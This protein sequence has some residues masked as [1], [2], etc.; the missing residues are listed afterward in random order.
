MVSVDYQLAA[1]RRIMAMG[2]ESPRARSIIN[3]SRPVYLL[4]PPGAMTVPAPP[5][6]VGNITPA[7]LQALADGQAPHVALL[8]VEVAGRFE[9]VAT[10]WPVLPAEMDD[11]EAVTRRFLTAGHV[12]EMV[13]SEPDI[14]D[15]AGAVQDRQVRPARVVFPD[16]GTRVVDRWICASALD[17]AVFD[18]AG[19]PCPALRL[20]KPQ[21]LPPAVA[22]IGYPLV[23]G[24]AVFR[25]KADPYLR[26][27]FMAIGKPAE[28]LGT[29]ARKSTEFLHDATTLPGFSGAPVFDPATGHVVGMHVRGSR[30]RLEHLPAGMAPRVIDRDRND[31][32]LA[33]GM[34]KTGWLSQILAGQSDRPPDDAPAR[35]WTGGAVPVP[36]EAEALRPATILAGAIAARQNVPGP[37]DGIVPDRPDSRDRSYQPGLA[38]VPESIVPKPGPVGDQGDEGSCAAFALAAAI[39][40]QLAERDRYRPPERGFTAS[41]RMLDR[42][43]RRHDEWLDDTADGTSLRAVIKGFYHN[44]VCTEALC[45]YVPRQPAFFL[46]RRIAK[47]ARGMTLGTYLRV[48]RSV[49][50]MR[51]AIREAGAVIVAADVHD[52]WWSLDGKGRIPYDMADTPTPRGR[53]AFVVRGYDRDGFIVQNARGRAWGGYRG[54]PGHALWRYADWAENCH[55]AWVIRLAPP[56]DR[57]FAVSGLADGKPAAPRRLGLLG[58]VLRAER[59]GLVEDGTLGIGAQGVAETAAY[60]DSD[61]ARKRYSRLMLVFHEPLMDGDLI[62]G[63]ALRLT[64]R[65]KARGV[66]PF[67]V[68]Y[69]LDEMLSCRLRLSHD[70]G[71]A[72]ERYLREGT[73]RDAALQRRLDPVIRT[74]VEHLAQGAR[75]A[76]GPLLRDALAAL[77][78]FA[79]PGRR[80]DVVSIGLGGVFAQAVAR[81]SPVKPLP[82]LAVACPLPVRGALSWKLGMKQDESDLPGWL[83]SWGDIVSR[84]FG[85]SIRAEDGENVATVQELMVQP[86]FVTRL[87]DRLPQRSAA[88]QR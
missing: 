51:M 38:R 79:A 8:E 88:R 78:L 9:P 22:V 65:L 71:R 66:Y 46:T 28:S 36:L 33:S 68:I 64:A 19:E 60:L 83:G 4:P 72:V 21:K 69:G 48:A 17:L 2:A 34:M 27:Q 29:A 6:E 75:A 63:L 14:L 59:S 7:Q 18:V 11:A 73:S 44:G 86:D 54:L 43:A 42:M 82:H 5:H 70:I 49:D 26:K 30:E 13:L 23:P 77:L 39:E 52:G 80:V 40:C 74:H 32:I 84:A 37:E 41:V 55:D 57:A 31:G 61:G 35:H 58:H 12:L 67:H 15:F 10:A 3:E 85:R 50:D 25:D 81:A 56:G 62:A 47:A 16:G 45:P 76:A 20:D 24:V 53:H 87:L 1:A